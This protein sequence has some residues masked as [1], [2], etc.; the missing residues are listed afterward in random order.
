MLWVHKAKWIVRIN[1]FR[2]A[3]EIARV[4]IWILSGMKFIYSFGFWFEMFT[5]GIKRG[6]ILDKLNALDE[7]V[8][9]EI[10]AVYKTFDNWGGLITL[11]RIRCQ[12]DQ[13]INKNLNV[14]RIYFSL[15][16]IEST[17]HFLEKRGVTFMIEERWRKISAGKSLNTMV[18]KNVQ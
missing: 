3:F 14:L 16:S 9:I 1:R 15:K 12:F 11:G 6:W 10:Q 13:Q 2:K 18:C 8:A 5:F 17:E 7:L 4:N